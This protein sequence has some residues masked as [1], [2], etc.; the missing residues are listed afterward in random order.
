[1]VIDRIANRKIFYLLAV[2]VFPNTIYK[3][4]SLYRVKKYLNK[5]FA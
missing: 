1:M 5:K 4:L 3:S 2:F